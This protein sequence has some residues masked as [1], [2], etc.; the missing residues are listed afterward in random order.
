MAEAMT[1]EKF[2]ELVRRLEQDAGRNPGGYRLRVG[3]LAALGYGFVLLLFTGA[4]GLLGLSVYLL[5]SGHRS[6]GAVP[7]MLALLSFALVV[8]RALWVWM[9]PPEGSVL[10]PELAEPLFDTVE[11]LREELQ[12]PP[13]HRI[14]ITPDFNAAV[15]QRSRLGIFGWQENYLLVGLPLMQALPP[16]QFRAVLAHEMGHLRGGHNRFGGWI[17]RVNATWE[18]LLSRLEHKVGAASV[19]R[20]F[21]RW[22]SPYFA[23]YSFALR[24]ADEYEADRCAARL[25]VAETAAEAL[26]SAP[27]RAR[28]IQERFWGGIYR[29]A[30]E[31]AEPPAAPFTALAEETS[32]SDTHP[33][34][35]DR[36][37]A[38]GQEPRL[39]EAVTGRTAAEHYFGAHLPRITAHLD[40]RWH[41][42]IAPAWQ[43]RHQYAQE[44][45]RDLEALDE[46]A[47]SGVSLSLEEAW[48]RAAWTEEFRDAERALPLYQDVLDRVPEIAAAHFAVGR[49]LIAK[50]DPSGI[51][52]LETA[53]AHDH[54]VTLPALD[55][56]CDFHKRRGEAATAR[57]V[58]KRAQHHA[59]TLEES[60]RERSQIG[61]KDRFLP[62]GLSAE[63][64]GALCEQL[65]G[66][67]DLGGAYLVRK[68]VTLPGKALF[69]AGRPPER[70]LEG[71]QIGRGRGEASAGTFGGAGVSR[72]DPYPLLL[73][74]ALVAEK[75]DA[76]GPRLRRLPNAS[77]MVLAVA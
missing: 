36:L 66:Q 75:G 14:L 57:D 73:Q 6:S 68:E 9:D 22:Y 13:F 47:R 48:Q 61:R 15:A 45:Q 53:I 32:T 24:R 3:L 30:A 54:D 39:P 71:G 12:A 23:A 59:D 38:L 16:E 63:E 76:E 21:F 49:L 20:A 55:L 69:R 5:A 40:Q 74:R 35:A 11:A 19:L 26:C 77:A 60:A 52:H 18:R 27:I 8:L 37:R 46:K 64:V 2:D 25:A 42:N 43:E 34:L 62:H 72:R 4:I 58:Y 50:D 41:H 67:K 51:P 56:L 29:R 1:R 65:A 28:F 7:R 44:A 31:E 10:T 17:Y 70:Q 33:A